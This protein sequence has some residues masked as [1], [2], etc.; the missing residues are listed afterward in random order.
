MKTN[1]II[2]LKTVLLV[3]AIVLNASTVFSQA[4]GTNFDF[5]AYTPG[6]YAGWRGFQSSNNSSGNTMSLSTWVGFNDPATCFW[7]GDRCFIINSNPNETDTRVSSGTNILKKIPTGYSRSSQINCAQNNRNTNMLTY[8]LNVTNQNCLLTFNFAMILESPGHGGYED[9]FFKIDVIKLNDVTEAEEGLVQTCATFEVKGNSSTP[10]TGWFTYSGGI[11]Q[12]WRQI[13]MNLTNNIGER[14]RIKVLLAGCS[15]S[16]HYAYG[17]FVGKVGPSVLTVNACGQGDTAAVITAPPGF[18]KYEWYEN[19]G[20]LPE[21][22]LY[23]LETGPL[24]YSSEATT[25][26]PANNNFV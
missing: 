2:K 17:Y 6:N 7:Q 13:S 16:G 23:T 26:Q 10:P 5:N 8:D 25:T 15:A 21:S 11:W 24:L 14:V 4:D 9:P 20:N 18:A 1:F 22:Q 12:P 3:L 19:T